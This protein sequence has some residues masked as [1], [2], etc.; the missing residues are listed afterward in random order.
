MGR[1]IHAGVLLAPPVGAGILILSGVVFCAL[2]LLGL[3]LRS[4]AQ[5]KSHWW[6]RFGVST[7]GRVVRIDDSDE[8]TTHY[9]HY[10]DAAG[11]IHET[12]THSSGARMSVGEVVEVFVDPSNPARARIALD[13]ANQHA[14]AGILTL[15]FGGLGVL[16]FLLG[17]VLWVLG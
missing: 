15:A 17:L 10:L 5:R 12:Y 13:L 8:G 14:V 1:P 11:S 16:T 7:P 6:R 3:L 9:V 4:L 2:A